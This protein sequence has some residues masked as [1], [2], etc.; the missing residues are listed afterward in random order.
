MRFAIVL[1]QLFIAFVLT[2]TFMPVL[3]VTVPATRSAT[4]GP[5]LGGAM[6]VVLF[7]IIWLIWPR[8]R[9]RS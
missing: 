5:A 3:L 6:L 8:R 9:A 7:G 4:A 2:A 1:L